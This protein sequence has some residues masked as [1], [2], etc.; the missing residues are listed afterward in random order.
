MRNTV[1]KPEHLTIFGGVSE[2]YNYQNWKTELKLEKLSEEEQEILKGLSAF[3]QNLRSFR[4]GFYENIVSF[5]HTPFSTIDK[6]EVEFKP[7]TSE[8]TANLLLKMLLFH[9]KKCGSA[10]CAH[11]QHF[12]EIIGYYLQE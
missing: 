8:M 2:S 4:S 12:C 7:Q 6:N 10:S 11:V 9:R 5:L 1:F 3:L